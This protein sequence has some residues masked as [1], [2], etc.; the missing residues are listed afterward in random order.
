MLFAAGVRY[1]APLDQLEAIDRGGTVAAAAAARKL[2]ADRFV[3]VSANGAKSGPPPGFDDLWR[4]S[5]TQQRMLQ[6]RRCGPA[7]DGHSARGTH[8]RVTSP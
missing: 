3:Q 8:R 4:T 1:G 5:Y 7:V 6:T 2:G